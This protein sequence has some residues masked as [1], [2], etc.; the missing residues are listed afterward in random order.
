M[1]AMKGAYSK[2]GYSADLGL[3]FP[4]QGG[5]VSGLIE[6]AC[7][8]TVDG[9]YSREGGLSGQAVGSCRFLFADIHAQ[10]SIEGSVDPA[11]ETGVADFTATAL[12][13]TLR[14]TVRLSPAANR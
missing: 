13:Q 14:G 12:G 1:V 3:W 10:A 11:L 4:R 7:R 9:R 8:G 6:G 2:N 5:R